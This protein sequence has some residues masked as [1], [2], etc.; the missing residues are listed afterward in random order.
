[1]RWL[2]DESVEVPVVDVLRSTGHDV[3]AV[4]EVCPGIRDE[5]VLQTAASQGRV[6]IA[7]D[8]DFGQLIFSR[9]FPAAGVVLMRLSN[10]DALARA[11]RPAEVLPLVVDRA[12]G[13]F[14]VIGETTVRVRPLELPTELP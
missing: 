12:P 9:G 7:N 5:D 4:G 14:V 1:M 10:P 8:K 11:R 2:A 13:H 6:P 3:V